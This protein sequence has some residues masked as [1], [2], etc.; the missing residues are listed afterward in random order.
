MNPI[1]D[2]LRIEKENVRTYGELCTLTKRVEG[3]YNYATNTV[4]NTETSHQVY[5]R[6]FSTKTSNAE[7]YV[8]E[9]RRRARM[10]NEGVAP[11]EGDRLETSLG[12]FY[13]RNLEEKGT[14]RII[15]YTFDLSST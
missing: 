6:F 13:V 8:R 15:V 7:P 12:K 2:Y 11:E 9:K 1:E 5:V 10:A 14:G 3:T 4:T